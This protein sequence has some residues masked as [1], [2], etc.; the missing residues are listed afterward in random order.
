[1]VNNVEMCGAY[2]EISP[3][4]HHFPSKGTIALNQSHGEIGFIS[5][6]QDTRHDFGIKNYGRS[7]SPPAIDNAAMPGMRRSRM[8][9]P[10]LAQ[11][12]VPQP[13]NRPSAS[14]RGMPSEYIRCR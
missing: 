4:R 1:M 13:P 9:G 5:R 11:F 14:S 7:E 12:F 8:R 2:P 10:C 3:A 6:Y